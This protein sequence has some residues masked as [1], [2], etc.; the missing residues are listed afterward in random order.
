MDNYHARQGMF[1]PCRGSII[2]PLI[3]HH[4]GGSSAATCRAGSAPC[5]TALLPGKETNPLC[6][7][8][9]IPCR[10]AFGACHAHFN[11]GEENHFPTRFLLRVSRRDF[12]VGAFPNFCSRNFL[13]S[14]SRASRTRRSFVP[15]VR[16]NAVNISREFRVDVSF[17]QTTKT[18]N[19]H[20][21]L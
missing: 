16:C 12:I 10:I 9:I 3:D 21:S 8:E 15:F 4:P 14:A 19:A 13:L 20:G 5:R 18:R 11:P 17:K 6:P 2:P 1:V 7:G